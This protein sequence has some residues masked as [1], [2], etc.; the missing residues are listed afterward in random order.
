MG[1]LMNIAPLRDVMSDY[2]RR[3]WI[4]LGNDYSVTDIIKPPRIVQLE[5]RYKSVL[6]QRPITEDEIRNSLK[7]YV[8]TAVHDKLAKSLWSFSAKNPQMGYLVERKVTDKIHGRKIVGKF[9]CFL[10]GALYDWK[11]TSVWKYVYAQYD[12]YETQLNIYAYLITTADQRSKLHVNVL[13]IIM[14][15][16]DWELGKAMSSQDYP[17]D[18]IVQL[19][20][21]KLWTASEQ[22]DYIEGSVENHI[23][24]ESREDDDLDKCTAI[25]RWDKPTKFAIV[26]PGAKRAVRLLASKEEAETYIAQSSNKKRETW[27]VETRGGERVRCN[28]FCRINEFCNQ[29]RNYCQENAS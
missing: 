3:S 15:F 20:I 16:N 6:D 12:E 1:K 24:N 25:D 17:S 28:R 18:P 27:F 23:N 22:R 7:S 10:N 21:D 5:R 4:A 29:Y 2:L 11:T 14:W 13:Y 26:Q 9:D 8:G 19:H